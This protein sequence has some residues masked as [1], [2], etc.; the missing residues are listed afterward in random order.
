[1]WSALLRRKGCRPRRGIVAG[2]C[3]PR[4]RGADCD[5]N[6]LTILIIENGLLSLWYGYVSSMKRREH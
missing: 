5:I 6:E 1:M 3:K 4:S 2:G